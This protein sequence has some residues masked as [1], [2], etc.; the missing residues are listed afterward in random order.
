[1]DSFDPL[2]DRSGE[3][4]AGKKVCSLII[5]SRSDAAPVLEPVE[6]RSIMFLIV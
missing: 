2:G 6:A 1:V 5:V 4:Y 3:A